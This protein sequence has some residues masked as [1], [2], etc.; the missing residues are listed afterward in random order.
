MFV[1]FQNIVPCFLKS[2]YI[3]VCIPYSTYLTFDTLVV[4]LKL[5]LL[6]YILLFYIG[7]TVPTNVG[8]TILSPRSIKV[9]WN[10]SSLFGIT[11]YIISYTTNASYANGGSVTVNGGGTTSYILTNLEEDTHYVIT[12]QATSNNIISPS[13]NKVSVTT[14]ADSK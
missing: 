5:Y 7:T 1:S 12:V 9:M 14:S 2:V 8:A 13:S 4:F 10:L 11:G 3:S 6:T